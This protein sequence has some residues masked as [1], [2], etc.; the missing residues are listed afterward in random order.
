M[1]VDLVF[2]LPPVYGPWE[3][4]RSNLAINPRLATGSTGWSL[5]TRAPI[6][7]AIKPPNSVFAAQRSAVN[8][9]VQNVQLGLTGLTIGATYF[10]SY[11]V[12]VDREVQASANV[13]TGL[14]TATGAQPAAPLLF[15]SYTVSTAG[16][17]LVTGTFTATQTDYWA[18]LRRGG[19]AITSGNV[20]TIQMTEVIVSEVA[21]PF[22]DGSTVSVSP[23]VQYS[24][25]GT[26]NASA[27]IMQTREDLTSR[28]PIGNIVAY[29][30]SQEITPI[31]GSDSS[32]A[33]TTFDV[34]IEGETTLTAMRR[35]DDKV[36]LSDDE[37]RGLIFGRVDSV[38][39]TEDGVTLGVA[40]TLSRLV[41]RVTLE[42]Y[43]GTLGGYISS[44]IARIDDTIEVEFRGGVGSIPLT[45][46]VMTGTGWDIVKELCVAHQF[47]VAMRGSVI[48]VRPI[49]GALFTYETMT[50]VDHSI[51]NGRRARY[52][53][54]SYYDT[55]W[56]ENSL[57]YPRVIDD[58]NMS[59]F[60]T[61]GANQTLLID[62]NVTNVS[63]KTISQ[64][65]VVTS[66]VDLETFGSSC[67]TVLDRDNNPVD[68][69]WWVANGGGAAAAADAS[70]SV[71]RLT[72]TTP[73]DRDR[74]PFSLA[75]LDA[76]GNPQLS[77]RLWGSGAF[78]DPQTILMHTGAEESEILE[79]VGH[80]VDSFTYQ[81]AAQAYTAAQYALMEFS[82]P[83]QTLRAT[84]SLPRLIALSPEWASVIFDELNVDLGTMTFAAFN[85]MVAG[86]TF[87]EFN[88]SLDDEAL[89][90]FSDQ[91]FSV[92]AGGRI[93]YG[94]SYFRIVGVTFTES[95]MSI[96]AVAD[97]IVEDIEGI[98]YAMDRT[99][100]Y[101]EDNVFG[102]KT[103]AEWEVTPMLMTKE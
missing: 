47:E 76:D 77:V 70:G 78:M 33:T 12:K 44:L 39:S 23:L 26:A 65:Q 101:L 8:L 57:M 93:R 17:E 31:S 58:A 50:G 35:M 96:D 102:S 59:A 40:T 27:S 30:V 67:Y 28:R 10:V 72:I 83:I 22:F 82:S 24:W 29:S 63:A 54:V 89:S 45:L 18:I 5:T 74:A 49:R 21:G 62:Y 61:A 2:D 51:E 36:I 103:W 42:P 32:G 9:G 95:E 48:T 68:P 79:E 25:I 73:N 98:W 38:G 100:G 55:Q 37:R 16:W 6:V 64:P 71:I 87:D 46:P 41:G 88:E 85:A 80:S 13:L 4:A 56:S 86:M 20:W 1:A 97:T 91:L 14:A 75:K 34:E 7:D 84:V 11:W 3:E 66:D 81:N 60:P 94:F 69:A 15:G 90:R 53:E 52:I 43:N 99:W 19:S 92:L